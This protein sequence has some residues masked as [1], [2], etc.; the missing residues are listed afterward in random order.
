MLAIT[1]I[2]VLFQRGQR[3]S[4]RHCEERTHSNESE[5][6]LIELINYSRVYPLFHINM[7]RVGYRKLQ[8]SWGSKIFKTKVGFF[9]AG[10]E[11]H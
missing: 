9:C 2:R 1:L 10:F 6:I 8:L 4:A 5:E 11:P 3:E 7:A